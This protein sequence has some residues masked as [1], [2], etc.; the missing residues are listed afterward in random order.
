MK[1][2]YNY[3]FIYLLNLVRLHT[4]TLDGRDGELLVFLPGYI[5][6]KVQSPGLFL[7]I[8]VSIKWSYLF[9][10]TSWIKDDKSFKITS[11]FVAHAK[12]L[13]KSYLLWL[14]ESVGAMLGR[15]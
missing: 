3:D 4:Q 7:R 1:F 8:I 5:C 10:F 9:F 13:H 2:L 14:H 11:S 15:T 12:K 6:P